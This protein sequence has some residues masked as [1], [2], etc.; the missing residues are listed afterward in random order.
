MYQNDIKYGILSECISRTPGL[1]GNHQ[2]AFRPS[3]GRMGG[4]VCTAYLASA[5][6]RDDEEGGDVVVAEVLV[7]RPAVAGFDLVLAAQTGQRRL[8]DVHPPVSIIPSHNRFKMT[9]VG[10]YNHSTSKLNTR[11]CK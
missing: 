10:Q 3:I 7:P 5:E 6:W 2:K 1:D 9:I 11:S 4:R 8:G